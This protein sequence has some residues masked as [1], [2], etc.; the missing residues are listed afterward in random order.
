MT[1]FGLFLDAVSSLA[2][3]AIAVTAALLVGARLGWA[4]ADSPAAAR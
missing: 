4:A 2:G 3:V 1:R